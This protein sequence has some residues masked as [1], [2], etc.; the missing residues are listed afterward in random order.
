MVKSSAVYIMKM[1]G[2]NAKKPNAA[3]LLGGRY[4]SSPE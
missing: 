3:V 4:N 1:G 2:N